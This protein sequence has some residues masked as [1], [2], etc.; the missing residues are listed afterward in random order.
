M[1]YSDGFL[2]LLE[3]SVIVVLELLVQC[4]GHLVGLSPNAKS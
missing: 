1:V 2:S 4:L 3:V